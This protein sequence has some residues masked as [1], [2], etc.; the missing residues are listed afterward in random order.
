LS[1]TTFWTGF[2]AAFAFFF[3]AFPFGLLAAAF[4]A[5]FELLAFG[6]LRFLAGLGRRAFATVFL[7]FCNTVERV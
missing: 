7:Q 4:F 2:A 3:T 1:S 5:G 6:A